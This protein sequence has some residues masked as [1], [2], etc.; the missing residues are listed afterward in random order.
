MGVKIGVAGV[1][2][3]AQSFIP[4]FKVHPLVDEVTLCDLDADKLTKNSIQHGIP[5]TSPSLD[6]LLTTDIDAA[7]VIT[8]VA[9][10][11]RLIA[12][13]VRAAKRRKLSSTKG[14]TI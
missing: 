9:V 7:V 13:G 10:G 5:K 11:R 12:A 3:F 14:K 2:A 1:G 8:A 4:L 6:H